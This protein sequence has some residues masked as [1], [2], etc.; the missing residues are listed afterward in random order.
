MTCQ[1]L[2][3][4]LYTP[5]CPGEHVHVFL[6]LG[7]HGVRV[8]TWSTGDDDEVSLASTAAIC[9]DEVE[10]S[11]RRSIVTEIVLWD[12][13]SASS[14]LTPLAAWCI[15]VRRTSSGCLVEGRWAFGP[16]HLHEPP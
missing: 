14:A 8:S 5:R 6:Q 12:S 3:G 16:P 1:C 7:L 10:G 9:E 4:P 15:S 13:T 2:D 11:P